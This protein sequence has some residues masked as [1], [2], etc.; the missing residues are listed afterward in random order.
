MALENEYT[1]QADKFLTDNGISF[2]AKFETFGKHWEDDEAERNIYTLSLFRAGQGADSQSVSVRFGQSLVNTAANE[3]PTA[4]DMLACLTKNDPGDFE[5][6]C[7][8]FGYDT[9][10]RKA[11]R[12]WKTVRAEWEQVEA[13]FTAEELE[14]LQEIN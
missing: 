11:E 9:D 6:F 3:A 2:S 14:Q 12:E 5:E 4:Y 1:E 10:S 7:S 13:F 8:E